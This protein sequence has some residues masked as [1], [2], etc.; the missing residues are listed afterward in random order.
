[1]QKSAPMQKNEP[2][3]KRSSNARVVRSAAIIVAPLHVAHHFNT[4]IA[5]ETIGENEK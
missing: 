5:S 1:M 3:Q 4:V 2:M